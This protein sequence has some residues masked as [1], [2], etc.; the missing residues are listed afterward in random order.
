[1]LNLTIN[2]QEYCKKDNLLSYL[3]ENLE[4][5]FSPNYDAL[6]DAL[7]FEEGVI[8]FINLNK[9]EDFNQLSEIIS[10]IKN[11]N[12]NLTINIK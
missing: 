4:E 11:I 8:N 3:V 7:S 9:Y 10:I 2:C 12:S 6:I 1:M 5:M